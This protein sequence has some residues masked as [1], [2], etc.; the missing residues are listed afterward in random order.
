[1]VLSTSGEHDIVSCQ[2]CEYAS[3]LEKAEVAAKEPYPNPDEKEE[4][5]RVVDT[6]GMKTIDEVSSFLSIRPEKIVKTLIYQTEQGPVA[7]L[8]RGDHELNETKLRNVLDVRELAMADPKTILDVTG[9]PVGFAGA[10]GL[11]IRLLSDFGI[12][13]MKNMV[14]GANE[15]GKHILKVNEG[16]DFAVERYADLRMISPSDTCPRCGGILEFGKGIEVGHVFKL[17]TKYS[18]ALK[19]TFLDKN[20]REV[21]FIMGC[22]GI[23][24]GRTIAAAIEQNHDENGI[25]FP[26]SISPFEVTILPL[27]MHESHVKNVAEDLYRHLSELGLA[28]LL[29][30]RDERPG[31]KFK[32]ADLLGIPLR[33]A[34]SPRTLRKDSIELKLRSRPDL[35]LIRLSEASKAIKETARSLYDSLK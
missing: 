2:N 5:L 8:V 6:P 20:G 30:D 24:I 10:V 3:N 22:Y 28:V 26:I 18:D 7:V 16:R 33:V 25:V 11:K 1:M 4:P 14:M 9:A 23:G 21:P 31:F 35:K 17:G 15:E 19:A 32:D 34:V 29:D 27:E 12:K 13:G